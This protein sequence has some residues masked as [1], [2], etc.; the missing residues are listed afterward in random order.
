MDLLERAARIQSVLY[1]MKSAVRG[2][3]VEWQIH[4]SRHHDSPYSI[5][6][7]WRLSRDAICRPEWK[8]D[9]P[10]QKAKDVSSM[11]LNDVKHNSFVTCREGAGIVQWWERSPSTNV[12]RVRFPDPASYVGWVCCWFSSLLREVFLRVLWF[13]PLLKNQHF[14]IPIRSGL[15]SSTLSWASGSGD[16]ATA[17]PVFD[18]KFS[19]TFT[20]FDHHMAMS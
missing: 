5:C 15:L 4:S 7:S 1:Q 16:R 18:M 2:P 19:F 6:A 13:S 12:S 20:F 14:Q 10:E 17:L 11:H 3:P 8:L 9:T